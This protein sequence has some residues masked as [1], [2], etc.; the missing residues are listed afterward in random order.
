MKI[1]KNKI[2]FVFCLFSPPQ[3]FY[4]LYMILF[5]IV[6]QIFDT[7]LLHILQFLFIENIIN[8]INLLSFI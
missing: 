2:P 8:I 1:E 3:T 4:S 5:D 6:I 7:L